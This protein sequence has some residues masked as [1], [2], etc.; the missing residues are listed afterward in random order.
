M[1]FRPDQTRRTL[2]LAGAAAVLAPSMAAAQT[3]ASQDATAL[4]EVVVTATKTTQ[5]LQDVPIS[6]SAYRQERMDQLGIRNV[7]DIATLTPGVQIE[8]VR[9]RASGTNISIRGV[10][11]RIGAGTTGIYI[12]DAPIQVR[13]IGYDATNVYPL[14]FDLERVEVL[15]G[16]QGTLYGAGSMG[17]NLR[18]ITPKP[19]LSRFQAYGR[20]EVADTA[21][22]G[23]SYEAGA[24]VGAPIIEDRM[25]LRVSAWARREGGWVDRADVRT[26]A[27]TDRNS[28]YNDAAVVRAALTFAA[29]DALT[30]TPSIFYQTLRVNDASSY[31][32]NLSERGADRYLNGYPL[33]QDYEDHFV[34]P[35]LLVE[36]DLGPVRLTSSTSY[37]KRR[38]ENEWDYSTVVPAV[39]SSGAI[40]TL[41][42][43]TAVA[44]FE[45]EQEN[46]TQELRLQN[47]DPDARLTWVAGLF[48]GNM[49]QT[50]LQSIDA[51]NYAFL[52]RAFGLP[53]SALPPLA[54]AG[55]YGLSTLLIHNKTVDQQFAIFGEANFKLTDRLTLTG[56]LRIARTKLEFANGQ[57][58]PF[59]GPITGGVASQTATP[60]TPKVGLK[61]DIDDRNMVY[62]TAAKGYRIGG[63]NAALPRDICRAEM[64]RIGISAAPET[65]DADTLWSYEVGAKNTLLDGRLELNSS[66]FLVDWKDIQQQVFLRCAFQYV[67]NVGGA[68]SVGF[69]LQAR[70]KVSPELTLSGAVGYVHAEYTSDAYPNDNRNLQP[71]VADGNSL[72]IQP[73]SATLTA[74]YERPLA[75]E[76]ALYANATVTYRSEDKGRTPFLEPRSVSYD[77][78]RLNAEAY[79]LVNLR[80]GVRFDTWDLSVFAENLFNDDAR[81]SRNHD[82]VR[83][84]IFRETSLRPRTVG[85][86]TTYR[87]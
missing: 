22:G 54:D 74:D 33:Y 44:Y 19:S 56:G 28:D 15:R 47:A 25:A 72:G 70:L 71:L 17:G 81:L 77:P 51:V 21:G 61:F 11:S 62:V 78:G 9:E 58:G 75:G 76:G 8:A 13:V 5:L 27:I 50:N 40:Q 53:P 49:R 43:Y 67:E 68:R 32:S 7:Q 2:L 36:Y 55:E 30:I 60:V 3:V 6:I 20:G 83:T 80:A 46:L 23:L 41:P 69:D 39:L 63:G 14:V 79:T 86:T 52:L 82:Q 24:A 73:W 65:Y 12:D 59:N 57:A 42:G 45:D 4:E 31:W 38:A 18:F 84:T 1:K 48:Y 64:D 85:V 87:Y 26:G 35:N 16:P 29:T 37:F 10:S 66:A 34:L